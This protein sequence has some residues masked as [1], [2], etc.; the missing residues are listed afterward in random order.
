MIIVF[1]FHRTRY[2][3]IAIVGVFKVHRVYD[4][5]EYLESF[6]QNQIWKA[7]WS[8]QRATDSPSL[9]FTRSNHSVYV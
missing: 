8:C 3:Q 2:T 4:H 5:K 6:Q 7:S 1:F 9:D